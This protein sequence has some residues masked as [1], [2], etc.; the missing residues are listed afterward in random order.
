[1]FCNKFDIL[2]QEEEELKEN[3]EIN[4]E[5]NCEINEDDTSNREFSHRLQ[6]NYV[7]WHKK[8]NLNFIIFVYFGAV[9]VEW[10]SHGI[11][12][13]KVVSMCVCE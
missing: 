12:V 8:E 3:F 6:L 1:M 7:L 2:N 9:S 10:C 13:Y 11:M 5:K 4:L